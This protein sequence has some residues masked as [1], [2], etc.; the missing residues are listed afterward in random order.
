VRIL[1]EDGA[2]RTFGNDKE[3]ELCCDYF[4]DRKERQPIQVLQAR[5]ARRG[6]NRRRLA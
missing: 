4:G 5:T 3:G 1:F 2:Q 6:P